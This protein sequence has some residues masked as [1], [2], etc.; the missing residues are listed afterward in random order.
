MY[1]QP[2]SYGHDNPACLTRGLSGP[3]RGLNGL[4]TSFFFFGLGD[5]TWVGPIDN[6]IHL[7]KKKKGNPTLPLIPTPTLAGLARYAL[8]TPQSP[9]SSLH[10]AHN[11]KTQN[12]DSLILRRSLTASVSDLSHLAL[13]LASL[14]CFRIAT[15]LISDLSPHCLALDLCLSL[16]ASLL[17][18]VTC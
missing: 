14:P 4:P 16:S 7:T 12:S 9:E 8:H 18:A 1:R 2:T 5:W 13:G 3:A 11:Q 15:A 6:I 17:V 10:T